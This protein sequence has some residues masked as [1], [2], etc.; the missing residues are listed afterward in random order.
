MSQN[1]RPHANEL[2]LKVSYMIIKFRNIFVVLFVIIILGISYDTCVFAGTTITAADRSN[3]YVD[4]TTSSGEITPGT[5]SWM[6]G[7]STDFGQ[8]YKMQYPTSNSSDVLVKCIYPG[9]FWIDRNSGGAWIDGY[10][11][12]LGYGTEPPAKAYTITKTIT[13][14][15]LGFDKI[16]GWTLARDVGA[17]PYSKKNKQLSCTGTAY[18]YTRTYYQSSNPTGQWDFWWNGWTG[19]TGQQAGGGWYG[20]DGNF[21]EHIVISADGKSATITN[22]FTISSKGYN[23]YPLAPSTLAT[24]I[25]NE[26]TLRF[27]SGKTPGNTPPSSKVVSD[28]VEHRLYAIGEYI[29]FFGAMNPPVAVKQPMQARHMKFV[30]ELKEIDDSSLNSKN[31]LIDSDGIGTNPNKPL[32]IK[33]GY[34]IPI[35]AEIQE[36]LYNYRNDCCCNR[37][38]YRNFDMSAKFTVTTTFGNDYWKNQ[39]YAVTGIDTMQ[40]FRPWEVRLEDNVWKDNEKMRAALVHQT[41]KYPLEKRKIYTNPAQPNGLYIITVTAVTSTTW[42]E[43][44][45]VFHRPCNCKK[46]PTC[47]HGHKTEWQPRNE[48]YTDVVNLYVYIKGSMFDDDQGV[49]TQ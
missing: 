5:I 39:K 43:N 7:S 21:E 15:E 30:A 28:L 45:A 32:I 1:C 25:G 48:T 6:A 44:V 10:K 40:T 20:K 13:A 19:H 14:G 35:V 34:G 23:N 49:I 41:N 11:T 31:F 46:D 33:A 26:W 36:F 24:T 3:G 29:Y 47:C 42:Q 9:N 2:G 4:E 16:I 8:S 22:K 18:G 38:A 37:T 27:G 17:A 12:N